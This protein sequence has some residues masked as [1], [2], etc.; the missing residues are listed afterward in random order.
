MSSSIKT[1]APAHRSAY[2]KAMYYTMGLCSNKGIVKDGTNFIDDVEETVN[3]LKQLHED[4][5]GTETSKLT[6]MYGDHLEEKGHKSYHARYLFSCPHGTRLRELVQQTFKKAIL[7]R[8][9]FNGCA[10]TA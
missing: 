4:S 7:D 6:V 9:F 3:G 8:S 10:A 5:Y 1:S 2:D